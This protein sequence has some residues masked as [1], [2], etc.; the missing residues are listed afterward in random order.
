MTDS[1]PPSRSRLPVWFPPLLGILVVLALFAWFVLP[2]LR[3]YQFNGTPIQ[4]VMPATDFTLPVTGTFMAVAGLTVFVTRH[5][6][7]GL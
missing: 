5:V 1:K 6:I 3:P 7:G 2:R 4:S